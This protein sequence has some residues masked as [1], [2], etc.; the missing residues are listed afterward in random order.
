[1]RRFSEQGHSAGCSVLTERCCENGWGVGGVLWRQWE[2]R[3]EGHRTRGASRR[4]S[5]TCDN[6]MT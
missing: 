1:M 6:I 2:M 5:D 3:L 4:A